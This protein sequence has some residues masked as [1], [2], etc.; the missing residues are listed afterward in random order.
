M[1]REKKKEIDNLITSENLDADKVNEIIIE[2]E[3]SERLKISDDIFKNKMG[4]VERLQQKKQ[5][6]ITIEEL[7]YKYS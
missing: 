3:F 1:D 2:Y 6:Q 7:V 4:I 5:L